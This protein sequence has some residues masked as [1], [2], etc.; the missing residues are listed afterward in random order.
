MKVIWWW[1]WWV[2]W[3]VVVGASGDCQDSSEL[4]DIDIDMSSSCSI[5]ANTGTKFKWNWWVDPSRIFRF[6]LHLAGNSNVFICWSL[7]FIYKLIKA[8][9]NAR[10]VLAL[11]GAAEELKSALNGILIFMLLRASINGQI[12]SE[13]V[14]LSSFIFPEI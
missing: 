4:H 14:R 13:L 3:W 2:A 7:C 5:S 1:W 8:L 11:H 9:I 6:E 12:Y 10:S